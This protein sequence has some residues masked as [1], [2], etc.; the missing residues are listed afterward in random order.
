MLPP[1]RNGITAGGALCPT[2]QRYY[3]PQAPHD[4]TASIGDFLPEE[5]K[6]VHFALAFVGIFS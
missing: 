2:M 4:A 1:A 5:A 6:F 3:I